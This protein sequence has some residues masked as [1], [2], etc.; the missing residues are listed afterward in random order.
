[1][2]DQVV[3]AQRRGHRDVEALAEAIHGNDEGTVA[4]FDYFRRDAVMLIAEDKGHVFRKVEL[5]DG[6]GLLGQ[7]AGIQFEIAF[8]Q[9]FEAGPGLGVA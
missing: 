7:Q 9:G 2:E 8:P 4:G 5:S 3:E 6:T 1:M